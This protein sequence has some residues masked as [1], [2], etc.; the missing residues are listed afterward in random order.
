MHITFM[1]ETSGDT[2]THT[3]KT[4]KKEGNT[5]KVKGTGK[6]SGE[7]YQGNRLQGR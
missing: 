3:E 4:K 5:L 6:T 2:T 1:G 7:N